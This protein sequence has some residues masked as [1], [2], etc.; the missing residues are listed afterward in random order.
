MKKLNA[1]WFL[2]PL[3]TFFYL[4]AHLLIFHVRRQV[5]AMR[6]VGDLRQMKDAK[7]RAALIEGYLWFDEGKEKWIVGKDEEAER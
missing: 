3:F 4:L 7:R 6:V 5:Y 1:Y 2:I